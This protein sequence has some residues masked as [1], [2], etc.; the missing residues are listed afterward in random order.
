MKRK[1]F[2]VV[3][4]TVAVLA[5]AINENA[6]FERSLKRDIETLNGWHP[7]RRRAGHQQAS[8][9][10]EGEPGGSARQYRDR[11]FGDSG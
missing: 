10:Q 9:T 2:A 6:L 5:V 8:G 3:S 11:P 1:P 7:D 4:S